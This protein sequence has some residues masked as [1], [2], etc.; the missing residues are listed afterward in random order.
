MI[1]SRQAAGALQALSSG[2]DAAVE[3]AGGRHHL[4]LQSCP[5]ISAGDGEALQKK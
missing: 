2:G 4:P 5:L 3:S 1:I